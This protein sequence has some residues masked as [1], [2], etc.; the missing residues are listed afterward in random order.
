M[1]KKCIICDNPAQYVIKDTSDGYCQ[2]C[3]IECFNDTSLLLSVE[4]QAQELKK[5]IKENMNDNVGEVWKEVNDDTEE[6]VDELNSD[7]EPNNF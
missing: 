7:G 1:P 5:L 2:E 6:G 4:E 3:A